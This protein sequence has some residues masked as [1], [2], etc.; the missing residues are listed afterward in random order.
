MDRGD[1]EPFFQVLSNKDIWTIL[2]FWIKYYYNGKKSSNFYDYSCGDLAVQYNYVGLIKESTN[3]TFTF[4]STKY[5]SDNNNFDMVKYLY[6][7]FVKLS[8]WTIGCSSEAMISAIQNNNLEMIEF[9]YEKRDITTPCLKCRR[10]C[11]TDNDKYWYCQVAQFN[12]TKEICV[13]DCIRKANVIGNL[14]VI[15][16][17]LSK[18]PICYDHEELS[19][20][21]RQGHL[22]IVKFAFENIKVDFT[23]TMEF[24][25]ECNKLDIVKFLYYNE[26]DVVS[27]SSIGDLVAS[28]GYLDIVKFF[29]DE[30]IVDFSDEAILDAASNDHVE[31]VEFLHKNV[32]DPNRKYPMSM[33]KD[34]IRNKRVDTVEYLVKN[35]EEF[36]IAY[37]IDYAENLGLDDMVDFLMDLDIIS[38]K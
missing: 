29:Y 2:K 5:S 27:T 17:F 20:S 8:G 11:K 18:D 3:L 25:I 16:F 34:V 6:S 30:D 28:K 32:E 12:L 35:I 7:R 23:G 22:H 36:T 38:D 4:N 14:D 9:L 37:A 15:K 31:V 21:I 33:F 26:I 24:A 13:F 19:I 1:E 10:N